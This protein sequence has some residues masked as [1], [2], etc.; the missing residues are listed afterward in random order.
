MSLIRN[1]RFLTA[2]RLASSIMI[3]TAAL[4]IVAG[5]NLLPAAAVSAEPIQVPSGSITNVNISNFAFNPAVVTITVGSSVRWTNTT[6]STPHTST[7][8]TAGVWDSGTINGG[9]MF[10]VTFDAPGVYPYHCNF[11][12]SMHGT[13]VVIQPPVSVDIAGP[14]DGLTNTVYTFTATVSPLTTTQP[15]AFMWQAT[16]QSPITH[17]SGLS[18]SMAFTW[19]TTGTQAITVTAMNISGTV[20]SSHLITISAPSVIMQPPT[21]VDI[22]GPTDGLT[23]TAYTF[24]ATVSPLTAT[25]PITFVWQATGQ[26][27]ITDTG[28]LSDMA[29]FTW[30]TTGAQAITVT[31]MNISG[32]VE[33]SHLI[34]ISAPSMIIQPPTSVDI[35]G[36]TDGSTN[37]AY[38]FTATVSPLTTTQPITFM[39]QA[40]G[41]SPITHTSGLSDSMAFTWPTTGTQLITVTAMNISGTVAS[42]QLITIST[43]SVIIQP[44]VSVNVAGPSEGSIN[45]AY[46]FT[47]TVSPLTTTQPITFMWQATGQSPITHTSGLSDSMAFTWSGIGPQLITVTAMNAG[48]AVTNTHVIT[49][50]P[51]ADVSII[52]FAFEP[53][54][55][56]VTVGSTVTWINNGGMAHTTTSDTGLWDSGSL[57]PGDLFSQTFNAPGSYPYHCSIHGF[58]MSGVIVVTTQIYL[59]LVMK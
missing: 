26:L 31:A 14:T 21:S 16:G 59:P 3:G 8:D 51:P 13:I 45:M 44:P 1:H 11:H 50:F 5:I 58:A 42:S 47:A 37:T 19:P 2:F 25:Q 38:T 36:P 53:Q 4:L 56:T 46:T 23:N 33:S 40:T 15:I 55:L 28:G 35:A 20:A 7:S 10:T 30:P 49:V 41:Q 22:A 52:D 54:V 32:T 43:P 6:A 24:T 34:T 12:S 57:A 9:G 27:P 18:D 48:G 39:W 17:T 29:A